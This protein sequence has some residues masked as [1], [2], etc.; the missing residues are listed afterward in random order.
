MY[1]IY[2]LEKNNIP[3]YI[4]RTISPINRKRDHIKRFGPNIDMVIIDKVDDNIDF[5]EIHYMWLFHSWGFVLSNKSFKAFGP[6]SLS[7]ETK[8]KISIGVKKNTTRNAKISEA[9]KGR[10]I[11]RE[12][13]WNVGMPKGHKYTEEQKQKMR[14]PR[15]SKWE[16]P[17]SIDPSIIN[18]IQSLYNT[19]QYTKTQLHIQYK[20]SQDTI[21]NIV[22]KRGI[23]AR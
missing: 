2:Y 8:Q 19:G 1:Y 14:K 23:Y 9:N 5:W 12:V 11:G 7:E 3:F 22:D 13:T 20:L 4:G 21:R 17:S 16:R 18:E 15:V 6:D 10:F